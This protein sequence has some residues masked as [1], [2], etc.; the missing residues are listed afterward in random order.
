VTEPF[1]DA[2]FEA[3]TA[4]SEELIIIAPSDQPPI[5]RKGDVP[6]TMIAFENGCPHRRRL[7]AW[8]SAR[9]QMPERT[10]ELGSYHTM[11][12]CVA[13][14]MGVALVPKS[15]LRTFP[16]RRRLSIH[17]LPTGQNRAATVLIPRKG[18]RSPKVEALKEILCERRQV[19]RG[20]PQARKNG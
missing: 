4:F 3:A 9:C 16:D 8:Y 14:G 20:K 5:G 13:A 18:A 19:A 17:D 1:P 6:R 12:S 15:V 7:E 11:L 10:I 2:P